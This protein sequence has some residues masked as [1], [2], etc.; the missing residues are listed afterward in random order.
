M[1]SFGKGE[2]ALRLRSDPI[3]SLNGAKSVH[4]GDILIG[5]DEVVRQFTAILTKYL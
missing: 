3:T 1:E 4:I 2:I 5:T